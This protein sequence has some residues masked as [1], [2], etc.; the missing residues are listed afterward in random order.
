MSQLT[1]AET[2]EHL[3]SDRFDE[4]ITELAVGQEQIVTRMRSGLDIKL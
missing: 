1:S 2:G 3:W 4:Q